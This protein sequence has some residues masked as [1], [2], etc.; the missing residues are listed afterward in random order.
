MVASDIT[1]RWHRWV[2]AQQ[3][4]QAHRLG[5]PQRFTN[6]HCNNYWT[7]PSLDSKSYSLT[8]V[9]SVWPTSEPCVIYAMSPNI[10]KLGL[11]RGM[12]R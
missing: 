8:A 2:V 4:I 11:R 12:C 6:G 7:T 1:F 10:L 3:R 9:E 5:S